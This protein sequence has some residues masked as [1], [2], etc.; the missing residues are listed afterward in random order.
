M[1][2]YT[3]IIIDDEADAASLNTN[4]DKAIERSA[5]NRHLDDIKSVCCQSLFIQLTATPQTLLL[6]NEQSN[7]QPEFVHYFQAGEN[8][9][10]G[11]FVFCDPPSYVVWFVDN[12]LAEMKDDSAEIS[13]MCIAGFTNIFTNL[14]RVYAVWQKKL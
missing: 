9:I 14:C 5:V 3:L 7:W 6:Q 11:K 8:Y 4:A 12:E 1:K 13:A 2:D 10:G